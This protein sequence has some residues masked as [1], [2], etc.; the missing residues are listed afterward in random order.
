MLDRDQHLVTHLSAYRGDPLQRTGTEFLV[1]FADGDSLWIPYNKD[2]A[3]TQHFETYCRSLPELFPLLYTA[4]EVRRR[5]KAMNSVPLT[6][7]P[8]TKCYLNLRYYGQTLYDT[9]QDSYPSAYS[10]HF[11]FEAKFIDFASQRTKTKISTIVK[12]RNETLLLNGYAIH[13]FVSVSLPSIATL[14]TPK[15]ALDYNLLH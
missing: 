11:F 15:F 10:E 8:F 5:F 4:A 13:A 12:V 7:T 6:V 14:I 3:E 9:F 2:L 1:H